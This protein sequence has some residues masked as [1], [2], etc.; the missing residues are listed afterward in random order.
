M[1]KLHQLHHVGSSK[2]P[3]GYASYISYIITILIQE[4]VYIH[5][6]PTS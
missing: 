3:H 2:N 1:T 6:R 5:P 4:S